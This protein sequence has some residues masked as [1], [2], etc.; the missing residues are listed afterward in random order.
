MGSPPAD[1]SIDDEV[2]LVGRGREP[3]EIDAGR[4]D[5]VRAGKPRRGALG[6]VVA[7]CKQRVDP[8][9][10]AIALVPP[11]WEAKAL[12]VDEGRRSGGA[13]LEQRNVRQPRERGV[14]PVDDVEVAAPQRRR[15]VRAN[16]DGQPDRRSG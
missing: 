14:E 15:D 16:A 11:W 1:V 4:D 13:G 6:D 3:L 2:R 5:R 10:Q 9:Q 8:G 7:R 12:R